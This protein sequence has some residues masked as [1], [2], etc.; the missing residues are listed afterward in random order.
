MELSNNPKVQQIHSKPSQTSCI[1]SLSF[2]K[3]SC[4]VYD[5]HSFAN[6]FPYPQAIH[7]RHEDE[8]YPM[9]VTVSAE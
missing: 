5:W 3:S 1:N 6:D 4:A 2:Q 8:N 7:G 9:N